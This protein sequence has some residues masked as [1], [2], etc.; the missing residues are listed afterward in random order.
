MRDAGPLSVSLIICETVLNEKTESVSA[1]RIMDALTFKP[2]ARAARFFVL[3]Y[4]HSRPFDIERHVAIVQLAGLRDGK[5]TSFAEAPPHT[6][7]YSYRLDPNAPGAFML[8]TEFNLDLATLGE[9]GTFWVQLAVDGEIIG[10]TPITL[11]RQQH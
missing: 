11:L 10:R 2:L 7:V 5:W 4:L 1:I 9:L 8:T 6:F 3:T